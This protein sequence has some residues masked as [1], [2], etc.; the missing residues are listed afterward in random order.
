MAAQKG[1]N[2]ESSQSITQKRESK[3]NSSMGSAGAFDNS[4]LHLTFE[5]LN[6]KN[7][8]EWAQA[9][10]LVIDGKGKL[11]FL[12]AIGKPYMFLPMAKDVWDAIRETYSD[13][14]NASRIF[15]LK[16]QLWLMKQGDR[17]VT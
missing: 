14:K 7:Y 5:K 8:R 4:P 17:E 6:G 9:I 2:H 10:K 12:T 3:I 16:M 1:D 11:G 13:V 15:E